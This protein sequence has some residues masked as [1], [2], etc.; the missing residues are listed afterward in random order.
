ME[1]GFKACPFCAE[2]IREAAVVC[3]FCNRELNEPKASNQ[4]PAVIDAAA[5]RRLGVGG[6]YLI[7]ISLAAAVVIIVFGGVAQMRRATPKPAPASDTSSSPSP[8]I[9]PVAEVPPPQPVLVP[10]TQSTPIVNSNVVVLPQQ[11][12][13]FKFW[14]PQVAQ[15]AKITGTFHAFGGSGNDIEAG[16]MTPFEFENWKNGHQAQVFYDSGKVTNGEIDVESIPPGLYV[17]AFSNRFALM[18]RKEV[19][20]EVSLSYTV[21]E[22]Q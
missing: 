21:M 22:R 16:V 5:Q 14:V 7:G 11:I 4:A 8:T 19:T 6:R 2:P 9:Q 10:V 1:E 18:S 20:A 13:Y 17:L 3:R 15:S 12:E